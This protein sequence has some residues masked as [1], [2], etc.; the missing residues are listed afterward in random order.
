MNG[1]DYVNVFLILLPIILLRI[2]YLC[3]NKSRME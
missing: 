3:S 2:I 1:I